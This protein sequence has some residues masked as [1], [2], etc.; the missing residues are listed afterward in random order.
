LEGKRDEEAKKEQKK[1]IDGNKRSF[2]AGAG[3]V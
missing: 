3:G 1:R 2:V